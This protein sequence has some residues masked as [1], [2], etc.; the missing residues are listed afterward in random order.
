MTPRS[1]TP[2][3]RPSVFARFG[4]LTVVLVALALVATLASTGREDKTAVGT[5]TGEIGVGNELLPT[6][7][8]EAE[9]AGTTA[10]L[11]WGDKCDPETGR[12]KVPS[13]Y[14]PPCLVA[15]S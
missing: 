14:A 9:E 6:S 8:A 5:G 4:P 10:D 7:W 15:R 11:D 12:V 2:P 1:A 13:V 3:P